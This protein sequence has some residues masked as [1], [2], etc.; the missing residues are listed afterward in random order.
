MS[1]QALQQA[2]V[3]ICRMYGIKWYHPYDSRRSNKGWP[4]L[5]LCGTRLI[6]REL[7]TQVGQ[8]TAE[9]QQW[10]ERLRQAGQD[11]GVWRPAD[12]ESGLILRELLDIR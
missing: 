2:V 1:E 11:W 5:V 6:L 8:L 9:Q 7:K 12:L 10:G 4:D 3:Q